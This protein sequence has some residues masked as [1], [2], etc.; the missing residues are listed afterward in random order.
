MAAQVRAAPRDAGGFPPPTSPALFPKPRLGIAGA[1]ADPPPIRQA[2]A[3]KELMEEPPS[4]AHPS[5]T[6]K[7]ITI[8]KRP[9]G[10]AEGVQIAGGGGGGATAAAAAAPDVAAR[11]NDEP[12]ASVSSFRLDALREPKARITRAPRTFEVGLAWKRASAVPA[13]LLTPDPRNRPWLEDAEVACVAPEHACRRRKGASRDP[14]PG[15]VARRLHG[16]WRAGVWLDGRAVVKAL[17]ARKRVA[18]SL[19]GRD[20]PWELTGAAAM[21]AELLARRE[22]EGD[23]N[24]A[25]DGEHGA[26]LR[27]SADSVAGADG[28]SGE[29]DDDAFSFDDVDE[30]AGS[31]LLTCLILAPTDG[32]RP[33]AAA[34]HMRARVVKAGGPAIVR[35]RHRSARRPH[36]VFASAASANLPK[37]SGWRVERD[38]PPGLAPRPT[39]TVRRRPGH[40]CAHRRLRGRWLVRERGRQVRPRL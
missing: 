39:S 6:P 35:R 38:E 4:A 14:P 2:V 13:A 24:D 3:L 15:A 1:A 33:V 7:A 23:A 20:P 5:A 9:G 29:N 12:A 16:A 8:L 31:A 25:S 18:A 21:A 36:L 19:V 10:A 22:A 11:P 26:T 28:A 40:R 34:M 17:A 32:T 37:L 30:G 27:M